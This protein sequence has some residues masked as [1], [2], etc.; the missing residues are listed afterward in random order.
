MWGKDGELLFEL[1]ILVEG[2]CYFF[3]CYDFDIKFKIR[4]DCFL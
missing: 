2:G 4:K 3:I 1:K